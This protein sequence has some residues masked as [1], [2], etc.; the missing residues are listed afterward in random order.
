MKK[1]CLII[2]FV[3]L[4]LGTS[5]LAQKGLE[6]AD[7]ME[8]EAVFGEVERSDEKAMT[9]TIMQENFM[10][11]Q[12][13]VTYHI[14]KDVEVLNVESVDEI[15]PGDWVDLE[16]YTTDDGKKVV[17]FISVDREEEID[18]GEEDLLGLDYE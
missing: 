13:K 8:Y 3:I 18:E 17:D 4:S 2:S 14:T 7:W 6:F 5:A 11:A 12:E 16:Y 10:G 1:V 15:L 9:I